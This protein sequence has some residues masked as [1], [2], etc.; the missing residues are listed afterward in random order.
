M[1]ITFLGPAY[2]YRGGIA[3]F[4]NRLAQELIAEGH[5][6]KI[7]TFTVQYPNFLFPGKS[8]FSDDEAPKGLDITRSVNSINPLNWVKVGNK[9]KKDSPDI[10]IVRYW[11]PFMAPS[12]GKISRIVKK[13]KK[14][15]IISIVDNFIPHEKRIGDQRLSKYFTNSVDAFITMSKAVLNDISKIN[16]TKIIRFTPH[17]IYDIYGNLLD[18][19]KAIEKLK[20]SKENKYILFFGL[21]RDYKGLDL[22]LDAMKNEEIKQLGIKLIIAGE[23]YSNEEKYINQIKENN[24]EDNVI[25]VSKFIP[26]N[27]VNLYFSAADIIVQPYKTATQSGVTQIAYHFNKPMLVTNVGGLPEIVPHNKC[28][29]VV[30][31]NANEISNSLLDFYLN[32]RENKFAPFIEKEKEKYEWNKLTKTIFN[33]FNELNK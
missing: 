27:E 17:P 7:E 12:L 32:K 6:V 20:L 11:M 25:L 28:G 9:I 18:K 24:I 10:L 14:T 2:P 30:N 1:N 13:N 19:S 8:Q 3:A 21:I 4:N 29:Y 31:K 5:N 16:N 23:F 33:I 26:D 15:K 22:L